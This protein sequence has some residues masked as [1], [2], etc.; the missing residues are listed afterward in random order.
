VREYCWTFELSRRTS[1][2]SRQQQVSSSNSNASSNSNSSTAALLPPSPSL[3]FENDIPIIEEASRAITHLKSVAMGHAISQGRDYLTLE[4]IPIV[5]KLV[6]STASIARVRIFDLLLEHK[7]EL[8]T[9]EIVKELRISSHT[10][11]R[12]MTELDALE[13]VDKT[14]IST[15]DNDEYK[16]KLKEKFSWFTSDEFEKLREGFR[17]A[18][19]NKLKYRINITESSAEPNTEEQQRNFECDKK[20]ACDSHTLALFS[21]SEMDIN[22]RNNSNNEGSNAVNSYSSNHTNESESTRSND[23]NNNDDEYNRFQNKSLRE[24]SNSTFVTELD[25]SLTNIDDQQCTNQMYKPTK[26]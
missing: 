17:P 19:Y 21:A 9:S 7:G 2:N 24:Q 1:Y 4:D 18:D 3:D 25:K 22:E 26:K 15:Y 8:T 5:I 13:L 14:P 12:T 20:D 6:L 10:A 11:H 23:I 16:I